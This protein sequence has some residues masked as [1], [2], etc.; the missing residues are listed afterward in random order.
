MW[1]YM[2]R[3]DRMYNGRAATMR[4]SLLPDRKAI[5]GPEAMVFIVAARPLYILSIY[6]H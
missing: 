3:T 1:L 4:I 5:S 2:D 6:N